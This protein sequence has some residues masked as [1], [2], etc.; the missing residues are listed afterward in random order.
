MPNVQSDCDD[1]NGSIS[2]LMG[3]IEVKLLAE[4]MAFVRSL[5]MSYAM[6]LEDTVSDKIKCIGITRKPWSIG[7][8]D[9][10]NRGR[11]FE[12]FQLSLS[13]CYLLAQFLIGDP[14]HQHLP[15]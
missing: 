5:D 2:S 9:K 1:G 8:I 15:S 7:T 11:L 12:F 14:P 3:M 10:I 4:K 6:L 13:T